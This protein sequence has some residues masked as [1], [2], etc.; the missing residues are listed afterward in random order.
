MKLARREL[1]RSGLAAATV[2]GTSLLAAKYGL[3]APGAHAPCPSFCRHPH[4]RRME[5]T[6]DPRAVQHSA[7]GREPSGPFSGDYEFHGNGVYNCAA[8]ANPLF[9]ASLPSL[10]RERAGRAFIEPID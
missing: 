1:F 5:K 6:A 8:C 7:A 3:T 9:S 4:R 10:I 2:A